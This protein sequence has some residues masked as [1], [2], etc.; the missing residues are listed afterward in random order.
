L[1]TVEEERVGV[2]CFCQIGEHKGHHVPIHAEGS[3]PGVR[4]FPVTRGD[5]YPLIHPSTYH[6]KLGYRRASIRLIKGLTPLRVNLTRRCLGN[7]SRILRLDDTTRERKRERNN[8]HSIV[9]LLRIVAVVGRATMVA[10][11]V[12]V[13]AVIIVIASKE[14]LGEYLREE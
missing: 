7:D 13:V 1:F 11:V 2:D 4:S 10:M 9:K 6:K 5:A 14:I 12:V 3:S 8:K